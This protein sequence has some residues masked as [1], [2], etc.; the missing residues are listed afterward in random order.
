MTQKITTWYEA[1]FPIRVHDTVFL[2]ARDDDDCIITYQVTE[3]GVDKNGSFFRIDDEDQEKISMDEIGNSIF[4]TEADAEK[5][6]PLW[7][8]YILFVERT[9]ILGS[10]SDYTEIAR[11]HTWPEAQELLK[12]HPLVNHIIREDGKGRRQW[13]NFSKKEFMD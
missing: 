11:C 13:Y 7:K 5:A 3:V 1:L 12:E 10:G 4:L 8:R 6:C 2:D 9:E